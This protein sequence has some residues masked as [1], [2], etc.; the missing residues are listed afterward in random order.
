MRSPTKPNRYFGEFTQMPNGDIKIRF[1]QRLKGVN[2][3]KN[4]WFNEDTRAFARKL[5]DSKIIN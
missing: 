3:H 2:Q 1:V 4:K 5:K